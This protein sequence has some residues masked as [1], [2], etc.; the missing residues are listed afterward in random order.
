[1]VKHRKSASSKLNIKS[2]TNKVDERLVQACSTVASKYLQALCSDEHA[3][4]TVD[5]LDFA[6]EGS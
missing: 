6:A 1:M 4:R 5:F 3:L 2:W